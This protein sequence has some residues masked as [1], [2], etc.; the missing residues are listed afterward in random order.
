MVRKCADATG[1]LVEA[2]GEVGVFKELMN[3]VFKA[4]S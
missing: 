2:V 4:V 1:E 3:L